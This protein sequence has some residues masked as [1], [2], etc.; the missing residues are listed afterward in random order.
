MSRGDIWDSI[1]SSKEWGRYPSE[2]LIR[3]IARNFYKAEKRSSIKILELGCGGVFQ[4][5][6]RVNPF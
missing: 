6:C 3:F 5:S 1:F 4:D 2:D